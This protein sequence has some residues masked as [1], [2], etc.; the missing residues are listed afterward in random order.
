MNSETYSIKF[1]HPDRIDAQRERCS[2]LLDPD[3]ELYQA[4]LKLRQGLRETY[5]ETI[6]HPPR[7][8]FH[9]EVMKWQSSYT[10]AEML[11]RVHQLENQNIQLTLSPFKSKAMVINCPEVE[12]YGPTHITVAYFPQG[13]PIEN[14]VSDDS[15]KRSL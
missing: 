4:L 3:S 15:D 7:M 8:D 1:L 2:K 13:L 11:Q 10:E 6:A 5:G 14:N 12:G 9:V